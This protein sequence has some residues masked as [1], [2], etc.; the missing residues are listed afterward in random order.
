MTS[1]TSGKPKCILCPF[2]AFA[3]AVSAPT[4]PSPP[5]PL[6]APVLPPQV[7][8]REAAL[9]AM[10]LGYALGD[11]E[12]C[13]VMFVWEAARPLCFGRALAAVPDHV[14]VDTPLLLAFLGRWRVARVLTTP[15]LLAT[16]LDTATPSRKH[17]DADADAD[18]DAGAEAGA[19][20]EGRRTEHAEP[21]LLPGEILLPELRLWL[22]CGEVV[23]ALLVGRAARTMPHVALC[24][25][26]SSW[27]SSDAT[28][29][30][31]RV[32]PRGAPAARLAP[33]GRVLPSA[34]LAILD[35]E[36]LR[37]VAHGAQGELFVSSPMLFSGY[38]GAPE[39]SAQRLLPVPA[40]LRAAL[41]LADDD[42]AARL[43]RTGDR[44]RL[45]ADGQLQVL[46]RLDSTVKIRGFKVGLSYVEAALGALPGVARAAVVALLD[47]ATGQPVALV[48]HVLPDE[49][50]EA[51]A[52]ADAKAWLAALRLA[53]R[54]ELSPH[55]VPHHWMIS[56]QLAL[57]GGEA[58]KLDRS[59]LPKPEL[60]LAA[61]RRAAPASA[62]PAGAP[63]PTGASLEASLA[64]IW[65]NVL[66]VDEVAP[67]D[68]FFDLGGHSLLASK[69]V[70]AVS[71]AL[72]RSLT[73]FDLFDAPTVRS[74][75]VLLAPPPAPSASS[76]LASPRVAFPAGSPGQPSSSE[77]RL[78]IVGVAGMFPGAGDV[79][80]FWEMLAA[81]R[82]ALT[83]FDQPT[84]A[85]K[86]VPAAVRDHPNFV[87]A[88]YMVHG[89]QH[90][91]AAFFG[92][93][94]HEARIMDPQHRL[95]MQVAWGALEHAGYAP[96]SGTPSRTAVF[97]SPGID[98]YLVHHLEGKPLYDTLSPGD[99][100]L[101]EV[102]R[103]RTHAR[104]H[105]RMGARTHARAHVR[106]HGACTHART[107]HPPHTSRWAT[108]RT[109]SPRASR[110]RST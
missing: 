73:V 76:E 1:G 4:L 42:D 102:G 22:C 36:S 51:A 95:F 89:A 84:L 37:P 94:P 97:A 70:A 21:P 39:L 38:L 80:A 68:N 40:R 53:A 14:I 5:T 69:L 62:L 25:D 86:G 107:P 24:N 105:A 65:A 108:R 52:A 87:P 61:P 27:E 3:T 6:V 72:S 47:D 90:F 83:L 50:A 15:S 74:L 56:R 104:A 29:A 106:T 54:G 93:S 9:E 77:R 18:V 79:D 110:M 101:G 66:K 99:I 34:A 103:T 28:L 13:N 20:G 17:A 57:G 91:D 43:C 23:P 41:R 59:A 2:V 96:R 63:M 109:T 75:A 32:P 55:A 8:A 44:A 100:F 60:A 71:A 88:A 10:G 49:A 33:A 92:I 26:Y 19:G 45:M 30:R 64:A 98:G 85:A 67:E 58:K 81:G 16:L 78:A 7:H 48:A 31:L 11:V 35:P 12:A 82:D 46:G